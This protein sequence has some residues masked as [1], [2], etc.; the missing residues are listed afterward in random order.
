MA[1]IY[2]IT[3]DINDKVYIGKTVYTVE[4]RWR[5]H[6]YDCVERHKENRPLYN[7]MLKY[8]TEHFSI[9]IIEECDSSIVEQREQ[10]WIKHYNSYVGFPDFQ[11]YNA[12]LGGE[13]ILKADR[14]WVY[15]LWN[16][17]KT[18]R[19]IQKIT[20]YSIKAISTILREFDITKEYVEQRAINNVM[21][22]QARKVAKID[23]TTDEVI[24]IYD[25]ICEAE[26]DNGNTKHINQVCKGKRKTCKGYGWKYVD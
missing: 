13:G 17:G 11:G 22:A 21:E 8:G 2:K 10:Y 3:N 4:Q 24:H 5:Q 1:Y 26:R 15:K 23:L 16:E 9:E 14:D 12:T 18:Q 6:K 19:Q 20:T 7:A 25:S